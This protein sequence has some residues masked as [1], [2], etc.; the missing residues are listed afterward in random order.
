MQYIEDLYPV[1]VL[2]IDKYYKY[3]VMRQEREKFLKNSR[4]V[5]HDSWHIHKKLYDERFGKVYF[6]V[7]RGQGKQRELEEYL[8]LLEE[9][10]DVKVMTSKD[11]S[12]KKF[13]KPITLRGIIEDK[14]LFFPGPWR[15]EL[16]DK[17][18]EAIYKE[19]YK[20]IAEEAK[21]KLYIDTVNPYDWKPL[22]RPDTYIF[23]CN[24]VYPPYMRDAFLCNIVKD[25]I[26]EVIDNMKG[27]IDDTLSTV[28]R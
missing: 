12:V 5:C 14:D 25:S 24:Y 20:K 7:A 1:R 28:G 22:V 21:P 23:H 8:N 9:G 18:D 2:D 16:N 3:T 19:F 27:E 26:F 6:H 4:N 10:R 13:E 11:I 15:K 17:I